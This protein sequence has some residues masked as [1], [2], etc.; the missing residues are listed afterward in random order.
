MNRLWTKDSTGIATNGRWYAGD[1]NQLQDVVAALSDFLQTLDVNVLRV[2]DASLQLLKYGSGEFRM[3]G[4][5]RTD[6]ILRAL[7]G[8]YAGAFTTTTRNAIPTGFRPYGLVILNTV[9]NQL[10]INLGS[11]ATP[12]WLPVGVDPAGTL[13]FAGQPANNFIIIAS[14]TG[15]TN[16]RFR[17]RE[18]G[19]HEWGPGNAASDV[20]LT[21]S[22]VGV[23]NYSSGRVQVNGNNVISHL[24][25][26][27][28]N[29]PAATAV[30]AGTTFFATDTLGRWISDGATWTLIAQGSPVVTDL[31]VAPWSTPYDGMKVI[32]TNLL[33]V[34]VYNWHLQ[35][36]SGITTDAY[37]WVKIGGA[38][39][40]AQVDTN[41]VTAAG[42]YA[43][44]TTHGPVVTPPRDGI[45]DV[46]I[47]MVIASVGGSS[48]T[49]SMS[50]DIGFT[51]AVDADRV[52]GGATAQTPSRTKRK[53]LVG[54]SALVT[55]YKGTNPGNVEQRRISIDPVRIS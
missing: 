17:I 4:A 25:N 55:K 37:K 30:R 31:S 47:S 36:V 14:R 54:G 27:Y 46:E 22:G 21:R 10:E 28:A 19:Q 40:Q 50:Y 6:G 3:S 51:A 32:F 2:G 15:D 1:I 5:L 9:T 34:P 29:I 12:N 49:Q 41:E 52:I 7:G 13:T 35:Y 44:L 20:I 18:D 26:T 39:L 42:A 33:T 11:D 43:E 38:P 48:Q 16:P 24:Q 45:Y 8:F 23:L 53:T